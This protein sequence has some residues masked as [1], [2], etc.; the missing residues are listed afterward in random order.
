MNVAAPIDAPEAPAYGLPMLFDPWADV[1]ENVETVQTTAGEDRNGVGDVVQRWPVSSLLHQVH[2]ALFWP[3]PD[4]VPS[5]SANAY[6]DATFYREIGGH[7][8]FNDPGRPEGVLTSLLAW[9]NEVDRCEN[10]GAGEDYIDVLMQHDL[11]VE[12]ALLALKGRL[13]ADPRFYDGDALGP[14]DGGIVL[15]DDLVYEST[16]VAQSL[17]V[18]L[19]APAADHEQAVRDYCTALLLSPQF[20]L[21]GLPAWDANHPPAD[22]DPAVPCV[23][24]R[25]GFTQHCEHYRDAAVD[26]GYSSIGCGFAI[27]EVFQGG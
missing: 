27:E 9:E 5:L 13:L 2:H 3:A 1:N 26:L 25:C 18:S 19:D 4:P 15:A 23:D 7:V 12:Q 21:A 8:N 16:I 20:L 10:K 11:T 17:G 6:G 24:D 14:Q 22:V